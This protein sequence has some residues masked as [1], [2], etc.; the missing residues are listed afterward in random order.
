MYSRFQG[1]AI[2]WMTIMHEV[3]HNLGISNA[4]GLTSGGAYEAYQDDAT[5]GFQRN[6]RAPDYSAPARYNL[7]WIAPDQVKTFPADSTATIRALNEGPQSDNNVLIY[8]AACS[9]CVSL[10]HPQTVGGTLYI[11]LRVNDPSNTY[12]VSNTVNILSNDDTGTLM[13][14]IDRV[15]IHFQA[16]GAMDTE[17]WKTLASDEEWTVPGSGH[18]GA[19]HQAL[20]IKA[21]EINTGGTSETALVAMGIHVNDVD[22]GPEP[23][24]PPPSPPS[25]SPFPPPPFPP[26]GCDDFWPPQ[27]APDGP[28][29]F[30]LNG[31]QVSSCQ[32]CRDADL[33]WVSYIGGGG[34]PE[35]GE[36]CKETCESVTCDSVTPSTPPTPPPGAPTLPPLSPQTC[37]ENCHCQH[38]DERFHFCSGACVT[39]DNGDSYDGP[40]GPRKHGHATYTK[41]NGDVY[42]GQ[43]ANDEKNGQGTFTFANRDVF[44]GI[45]VNDRRVRGTY[46]C[47]NGDVYTGPFNDHEE[48]EGQG[49]YTS[50]SARHPGTISRYEGGFHM[51]RR[52][53]FGVFTWGD[54]SVMTTGWCGGMPVGEGIII[55]GEDPPTAWELE[56]GRST[57]IVPVSNAS[58]AAKAL[59]APTFCPVKVKGHWDDELDNPLRNLHRNLHGNHRRHLEAHVNH[60]RHLHH[61]QHHRLHHHIYPQP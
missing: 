51:D 61:N 24:M 57:G 6:W 12:G 17:L 52:Q 4:G 29:I 32:D 36:W 31:V 18:Q 25:P 16:A 53:G 47:D 44:I 60:R 9:F 21:C 55:S 48:K 50:H 20:H 14:M 26:P 19:A 38:T 15:H 37:G 22:C 46:T 45:Y 39:Y 1:D 49:V 41:A 7:G 30:T 58:K 54:G 59:T 13:T 23:P 27:Y 11:S 34:D 10:A 2:T 8:T 40:C 56:S 28:E 42:V 33:C 3:G 35:H 43:F 5:M